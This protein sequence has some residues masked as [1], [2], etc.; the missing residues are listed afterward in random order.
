MKF[1]EILQEDDAL[2]SANFMHYGCGKEWIVISPSHTKKFE[3]A[4]AK[5]LGQSLGDTICQ[6]RNKEL[7][8]PTTFLDAKLPPHSY[9]QFEQEAGQMVICKY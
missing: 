8:V 7:F 2:N 6:L 9:I 5:E 4:L 1:L 3:K